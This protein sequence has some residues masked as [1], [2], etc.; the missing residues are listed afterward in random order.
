MLKKPKKSTLI[1]SGIM[2]ASAVGGG[3]LSNGAVELI[4]VDQDKKDYVRGGIAV[5]GGVLAASV[6]GKDAVANLIKGASA[7]MAI[8]QIRQLYVSWAASK[9]DP[10]TT[11]DTAIKRF[12]SGAAGLNC[13][14]D[15]SVRMPLVQMPAL[16]MPGTSYGARPMLA[17]TSVSANSFS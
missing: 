11:D 9:V 8:E 14:C 13:A 17:N 10:A 15:Q 6:A 2:V 7:G 3:I 5:L 4:P 16:N 12:L 1:D